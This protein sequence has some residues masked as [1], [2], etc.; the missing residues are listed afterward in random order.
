MRRCEGEKVRRCERENGRT[1]EGGNMTSWGDT[2]FLPPGALDSGSLSDAWP[3][4]DGRGSDRGVS[5]VRACWTPGCC[6]TGGRS[7][8]V[9]VR[10][11]G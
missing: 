9:A 3:L 7:L 11:V 4:P 8:T 5:R 2:L 6:L 1:W 10:I